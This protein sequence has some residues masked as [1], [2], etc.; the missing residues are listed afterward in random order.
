MRSFDQDLDLAPRAE[1][2]PIQEFI[3]ERLVDGLALVVLPG[4]PRLEEQG[5]H[6]KPGAPLPNLLRAELGAVVGPEGP[7]ASPADTQL[8]TVATTPSAVRVRETPM[9]KHSRVNSATI[10]RRRTAR[11][12]WI[13]S[14]ITS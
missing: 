12:S 14:L 1:D 2:L 6:R 9:A 5:V 7:G 3:L 13:R 11:P 4:T 10:V 8:G